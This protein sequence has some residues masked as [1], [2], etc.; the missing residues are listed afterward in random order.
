MA[1]FEQATG[2]TTMKPNATLRDGNEDNTSKF[3]VSLLINALVAVVLLALFSYLRPRLKVIYSPRQLLE[4]T[5]FPLGKLPS[6]LFA[7]VMPAFMANDDDVFRYA[8]IDAF[9][10][11]RFMK[12]C[13]K[14]ALVI[15]PYGVA[16]LLPLNY[17]GRGDLS[18][19]DKLA[20]S[21][22]KERS[23]KLWAH[24]LAVWAYTLIICYLMYEEWKVYIVY[25]QEFLAKGNHS[26]Y[27][28]MVRDLPGKV[29]RY[30]FIA[31]CLSFN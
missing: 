22:V 5:M 17:F 27:V 31:D 6:S 21:N 28:V 8:G 11:L 1:L 24:L 2:N 9:V 14:I 15:M 18:G 12:L 20:M 23:P 19:L 25:R 3:L 16:V 30:I 26:Q 10:Y 4:D 13:F 7:W 29:S